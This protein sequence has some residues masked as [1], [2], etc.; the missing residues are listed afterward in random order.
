MKTM[1]PDVYELYGLN[2]GNLSRLGMA[3]VQTAETSQMLFNL[4]EGLGMCDEVK[5]KCVYNSQFKK[6]QPLIKSSGK[7]SDNKLY[8]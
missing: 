2:D 1:K 5:V 3:L 7:I 6:W 8:E 4:F